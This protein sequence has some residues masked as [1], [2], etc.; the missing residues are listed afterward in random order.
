MTRERDGGVVLIN[1]LVLLGIAASVVAVMLNLADLSIARSQR[2]GE[3]AQALA[4][5]RAGEQSA[6][7]ALRRD[8]EAAPGIDHAAEPWAAV[9][10]AGIAIEGGDFELEIADAQSLLNLNALPGGGLQARE[11]L[12]A[13]VASLEL[14]PG[15]ATR[16]ADTLAR[17]GPLDQLGDLGSR[18]GLAPSDVDRLGGLV[19]ALPGTGAVNVNTAPVALLAV[20]LQNPVQARLLAATRERAGFLT[21]DDVAAAGIILPPGVGF[22][23]DLY[24]TRVS[25][26]I[27]GT[28][29]SMESLLQ[30]RRS[31]GVA[32]VVVVARRN[33]TAAVPPPPPHAL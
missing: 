14:D 9:A 16:I 5:V 13:I 26:R 28:R 31:E 25:V 22:V 12:R 30:R 24:R 2:F 17:N 33:A 15:V 27:G 19:T 11:T 32:E 6:I 20:L 8:M 4:L 10:Q 18:A 21:T 3:A 23:S 29:Q 1:V 7:A